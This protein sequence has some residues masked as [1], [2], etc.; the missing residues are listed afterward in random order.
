MNNN[1]ETFSYKENE[2]TSY[3]EYEIKST[4]EKMGHRTPVRAIDISDN[5]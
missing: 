4:F 1:I 3:F 2:S 5:D